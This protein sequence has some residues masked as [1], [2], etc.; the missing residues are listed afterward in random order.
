MAPRNVEQALQFATGSVQ[1]LRITPTTDP[2]FKA[3]ASNRVRLINRRNRAVGER[4]KRYQLEALQKVPI[5]VIDRT[6][7]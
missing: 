5:L 3:F 1:L 4:L 6:S 2:I 7:L